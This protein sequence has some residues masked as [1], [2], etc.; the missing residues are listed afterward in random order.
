MTHKKERIA[1]SKTQNTIALRFILYA[2]R[3][4]LYL[5]GRRVYD[6]LKKQK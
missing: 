2:I 1:D 5:T 6:S 4:T 3:Y